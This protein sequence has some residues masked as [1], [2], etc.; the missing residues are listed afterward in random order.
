MRRAR[1]ELPNI[2]VPAP[3]RF[4]EGVELAENLVEAICPHSKIDICQ[5]LRNLDD[6]EYGILIYY[7]VRAD[8]PD[9]SGDCPGRGTKDVVDLGFWR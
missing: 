2:Q 4:L 6:V 1:I 3:R 8:S 9:S 7:D 5:A